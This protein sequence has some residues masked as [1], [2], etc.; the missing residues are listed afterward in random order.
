MMS[1]KQFA[2]ICVL[3]SIIIALLIYII[4]QNNSMAQ[5]TVNVLNYISDKIDILTGKVNGL[6]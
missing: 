5:N 2:I 6:K 1:K 3:L 4:Y